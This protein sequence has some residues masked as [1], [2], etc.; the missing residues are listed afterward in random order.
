MRII[1]TLVIIIAVLMCG[2][3][4]QPRKPAKTDKPPEPVLQVATREIA[5]KWLIPGSPS[6]QI[7]VATAKTGVGLQGEPLTGGASGRFEEV[8]CTLFD[9]A[10]KAANKLQAA[11]VIAD[12]DKYEIKASG[13][14]K[15]TSL[16]NQVTLI[17]DR[18]T[19][20]ASK[21]KI[22][23]EGSVRLTGE[24]FDV[25]GDRMEL[26]TDLTSMHLTNR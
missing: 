21:H 2:C 17:A 7:W 10:G 15:A 24:G 12:R 5:V 8:N 6:R 25:R 1:A 20:I 18:A 19:W 4:K 11:S 3:N 23:A 26:N 16:V 14:V 9:K 13:G 22:I